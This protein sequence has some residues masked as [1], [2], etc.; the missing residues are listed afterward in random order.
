MTLAELNA[1][2]YPQ[3]AQE[4]TRCCGSSRWV[5]EMKLI[6]PVRNE[7]TLLNEAENI[8]NNCS[9]E[10]WKEAFTHHP[11]IGDIDSLKEKFASTSQWAEG[12]QVGV[13][14]TTQQVLEELAEGN[15]EYEDKYGYIFIVCASGKS[16]EEMLSMLKLRLLNTPEDELNIAMEEQDKITKLRLQKLLS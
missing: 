1:L 11:K 13:Q 3:L 8:W 14:K 4:L 5:E 10:D 9:E 6:F 16:A 12:E 7:S 15:K 2:S